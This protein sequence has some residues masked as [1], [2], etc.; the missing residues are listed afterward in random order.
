MGTYQGFFA[1]AVGVGPSIGGLVA[2]LAGPRAPFFVFAALTL[3]AGG[4]ALTQLPETGRRPP[5]RRRAGAAAPPPRR[6]GAASGCAGRGVVR[7]LLTNLGF[8]CVSLVTFQ[9]AFTRTGAIF[10]VVPLVGVERIGLDAAAIGLAIT[11]G[12]LLNL[13]TIAAAGCW[14][15]AT[16]GSR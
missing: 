12:N 14:S 7:Q 1:F 3:V 11:S 2:V 4:V 8:L 10:S 16:G 6:P 13:A 15:T 5:R 9:A